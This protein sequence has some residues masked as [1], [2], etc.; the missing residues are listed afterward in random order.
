MGTGLSPQQPA[1]RGGL[2]SSLRSAFPWEP[3]LPCGS[4]GT[5]LD[6]KHADTCSEAQPEI[7]QGESVLC[8]DKGEDGQQL[9]DAVALRT[10]Q[11]FTRDWVQG[12]QQGEA[13]PQV[14]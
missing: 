11:A 9:P 4:A 8:E 6:K 12:A 10:L 5:A 2:C 1:L 7:G 13:G 14:L 3:L